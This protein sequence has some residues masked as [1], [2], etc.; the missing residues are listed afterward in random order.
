MAVAIASACSL[1]TQSVLAANF[2]VSPIRLDLASNQSTSVTVT[3]DSD[4]P[5]SLSMEA[6]TW[7]QDDKAMDHHE[8]T[9]ALVFQPAQ[10][11]LEP[12]KKRTIRVST[13]PGEPRPATE[14][15]Y[16]L[17]ITELPEAH[18]MHHGEAV[19]LEVRF[20]VPVFVRQANASPQLSATT[21]SGSP[22]MLNVTLKNSGN[23]HAHIESISSK[24][25]GITESKFQQWYVL[26]GSSNNYVLAIPP[27]LCKHVGKKVVLETRS[28]AR[29]IPVD[30][31]IPPETCAGK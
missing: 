21:V 22:G 18:A 4:K 29:M 25:E 10:M 14:A 5:L 16:R 11:T 7:M 3:N 23:A 13:K 9:D 26:A 6:M 15:A 24:P 20:G 12:K 8:K 27:E 17:Y 2:S 30:V 31:T 28:D 19:A 1:F